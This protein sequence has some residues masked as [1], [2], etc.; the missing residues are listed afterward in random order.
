[1]R[2]GQDWVRWLDWAGFAHAAPARAPGRTRRRAAS[3]TVRTTGPPVPA[4]QLV[5]VHRAAARFFRRRLRESWVP[6]YLADRGLDAVAQERWQAGYAPVGRVALTNHLL[7]LGYSEAVIEAAGL[8]HRSWRGTLIDT[9]RDRVM[10]PIRGSHGAIVAFIGR[11][12]ARAGPDIPKY[13]NS[14]RTEMYSKRAVLFGLWEARRLLAEGARPV[15]VEGPLDVMAVTGAGRFAG[16]APC[17]TA[18]TREQIAALGRFCNLAAVGVLVAFDHDRA[19]RKAA[20]AAYH[21][22]SGIT[23]ALMAG[24]LPAG[25]DPA[26]LL[27]DQGP[28][29]LART[30][31]ENTRP[32][33]DLVVDAAVDGWSRW[34]RYPEGQFNALRTAA[35]VIAAMPPAHV[36]RQVARLAHRLG[37]DHATVTEAVTDAL[38]HLVTNPPRRP[39]S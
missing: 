12:H 10:L 30:L 9:F 13:L 6:G 23:D 4:E 8:A 20:V 5:R 22:L 15:I 25:R 33:A 24:V 34:L 26:D 27:R 7:A 36:A 16:V 29:A 21:L 18:L 39:G 38:T 17:G 2:S 19:G 1:M 32:L 3:D 37:L 35:P 28:A 14:R 31:A 11:A